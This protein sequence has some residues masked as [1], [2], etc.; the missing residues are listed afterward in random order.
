M[1]VGYIDMYVFDSA[2]AYAQAKIMLNN[3]KIKKMS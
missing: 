1:C 3:G 2:N